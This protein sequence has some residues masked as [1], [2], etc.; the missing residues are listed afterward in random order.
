MNFEFMKIHAEF[1]KTFNSSLLLLILFCSCVFHQ[2]KMESHQCEKKRKVWWSFEIFHIFYFSQEHSLSLVSKTV[3][4]SPLSVCFNE[5]NRKIL[6]IMNFFYFFFRVEKKTS[7][8][9]L[10]QPHWQMNG[11]N[12]TGDTDL[13]KKEKW[14][15][16]LIFLFSVL[17]Y[18]F[19]ARWNNTEEKRE[20]KVA[21]K[22]SDGSVGKCEQKKKKKVEI[23]SRCVNRR[24][25]RKSVDIQCMKT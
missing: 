24:E 8:G 25:M 19:G 7:A 6:F 11:R 10:A 4:N 18:Q 5:L 13:H 2:V 21:R 12:G 9:G 3:R 22:V 20:K 23:P 15:T 14:N 1:L 16:F 17:T